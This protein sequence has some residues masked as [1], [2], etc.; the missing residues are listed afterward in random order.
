MIIN[1][2]AVIIIKIPTINRGV[3][4]SWNRRTPKNNAVTVSSA[5]SIALGVVSLDWM[6]YAV[7]IND[8]AVGRMAK[9]R[10]SA[11]NKGEGMIC[12]SVQ[13]FKRTM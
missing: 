2:T 4:F 10:T 6:A 11:H 8:T 1:V 5:P 9:A 3:S 12:N 13:K 7:Q